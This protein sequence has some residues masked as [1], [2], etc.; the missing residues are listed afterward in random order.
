MSCPIFEA[1]RENWDFGEDLLWE[2]L[3]LKDDDEERRRRDSSG[4]LD[5]LCDI[6]WT[7][8]WNSAVLST[9]I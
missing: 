4:D 1:M 8:A 3:L 2:T 6:D 7:A 9:P 5:A